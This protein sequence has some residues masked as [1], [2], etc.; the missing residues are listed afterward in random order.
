MA[1][2]GLGLSHRIRQ[3]LASGYLDLAHVGL[4]TLRPGPLGSSL[5]ESAAAHRRYPA[6]VSVV[7]SP[8]WRAL[9][10]RPGSRTV[11]LASA[12]SRIRRLGLRT[13]RRSQR[14]LFPAHTLGVREVCRSQESEVR[15]Q[16][17]ESSTQRP[18]ASVVVCFGPAVSYP[19]PHEQADARHDALRALA[20]G[21]LAS[22]PN[23]ATNL[24]IHQS[25]PPLGC[26]EAPLLRLVPG[27]QRRDLSCPGTRARCRLC[28]S[29]PYSAP[30]RQ[31]PGELLALCRENILARGPGRNLSLSRK[32]ASDPRRYFGITRDRRL[33]FHLSS[34]PTPAVLLHRL[35]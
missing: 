30:S 5:D 11:R 16:K 32:L 6:F 28:P 3:Q 23:S 1:G 26:R 12:A 10:Q 18:Q 33:R 4:P 27:S 14:I 31:R 13:Q 9:A 17:S 20:L 2:S 29:A 8:H 21:F 22:A 24:P 25:I 35:A 34:G 15:S 7:E 19:W